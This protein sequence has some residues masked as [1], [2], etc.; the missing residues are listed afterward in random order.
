MGRR[1]RRQETV[2]LPLSDVTRVSDV[3]IGGV[4]RGWTAGGALLALLV[5]G[6]VTIL[7]AFFLALQSGSQRNA[8]TFLIAG[9]IP[10]FFVGGIFYLQAII[11]ARDATRRLKEHAHMLDAIQESALQMASIVR[12]FSYFALYHANDIVSTLD[13]ARAALK[14]VPLGIGNKVLDLN[15]FKKGDE[16]ASAIRAVANRTDIA[17]A[18]VRDSVARAD[19]SKIVAHLKDLKEL[20]GFIEKELFKKD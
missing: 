5:V 7:F 16:F 6:V 8:I 20:A 19:A 9:F 15:Y 3:V 1:P 14:I 11:P 4:I 2:G 13:E 12:Q 10:I 18:D 17:V